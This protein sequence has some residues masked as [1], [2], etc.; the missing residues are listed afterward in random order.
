M[1]I[2]NANGAAI[3]A[4]GFGTFRLSESQVVAVLPRALQVG[5]RHID[6]AQIYQNESGVGS[7]I[8]ESG[9]PRADIFLTTK[10]WVTE[11]APKRFRASV[12]ASLRRLQTDYV[13]LLLLHWPGGSKVARNVQI[14][15]LNDVRAK[16]MTRHIGVSNYSSAQMSEAATLST[17]PL[18]TNQVEYHPWLSQSAVL[19]R[20]RELG[21]S[22]T[23]YYAMADGRSARE[24]LL[25]E[26]GERHGKSAAQVALRWLLQQQSV[27]ALSK[28]ARLDRLEENFS[29]FDFAL[30]DDEMNAIFALAEPQGRIVSPANL[31]P[32]WDGQSGANPG[33]GFIARLRSWL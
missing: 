12:E 2:I 30:S 13:D 29:V 7:A 6:T 14:A 24:P 10:V 28:T 9:V 19:A 23:A 16:G 17:A 11:F 31:A 15:E 32:Q 3:P 5:F 1:Q 8:R 18:V 25:R 33:R 27:I 21:M 22:V 4:L 26:I 20:A